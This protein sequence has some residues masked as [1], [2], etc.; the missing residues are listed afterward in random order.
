MNNEPKFPASRQHLVD[1]R[2]CLGCGKRMET[3]E[4]TARGNHVACHKRTL[5]MIE[6]GEMTDDEAVTLGL[7]AT[8]AKSGRKPLD[9]TLLSRLIARKRELYEA[10]DSPDEAEIM[11]ELRKEIAREDAKNAGKAKQRKKKS[12]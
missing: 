7:F 6:S 5:R 4:K 9:D 10:T 8:K 12:G 11:A 3:G 1:D 2:I